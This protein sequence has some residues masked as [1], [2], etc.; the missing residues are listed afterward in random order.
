MATSGLSQDSRAW[1]QAAALCLR[2]G[3]STA[4][5]LTAHLAR[6]ESVVK[7][8]DASRLPSDPKTWELAHVLKFL[9][10]LRPTLKDRTDQYKRVFSDN[11]IDGVIL[12]GLTTDKLEKARRC[13][14]C[15]LDVCRGN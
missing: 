4:A 8:A 10:Q 13:G 15:A 11:D 1:P 14:K 6:G 2:G 9:E 5:N 7:D 12:L 3:S